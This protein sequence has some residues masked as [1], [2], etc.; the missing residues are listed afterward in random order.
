M[1]PAAR[2]CVMVSLG[3]PRF[4]GDAGSGQVVSG[5]DAWRRWARGRAGAKRLAQA[6]SDPLPSS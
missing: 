5:P 3:L 4:T 6:T 2:T 1:A